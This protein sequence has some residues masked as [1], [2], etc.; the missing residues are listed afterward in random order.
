MEDNSKPIIRIAG[1]VIEND[2]ILLVKGRGY[3]YFWTPGGKLKDG[4]SHEEALKREIKEEI[5]ADMIEAKFYKEYD[6]FSFFKPEQKLNQMVY[7]AKIKGD[8][9]PDMEIED[10]IWFSKEDFA[11]KKYPILPTHEGKIFVDLIKEN[12]W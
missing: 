5:G 6:G 9:K 4:E 11:N 1:I 12:I 2:K 7:I 8:I 3:D 10:F